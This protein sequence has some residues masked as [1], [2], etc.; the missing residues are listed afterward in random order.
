VSL[1]VAGIC[2]AVEDF[3][4]HLPDEKDDDP[5]NDLA[6]AFD[7]MDLDSADS[8]A[9]CNAI[10][11][12][13]RS[14]LQEFEGKLTSMLLSET[15]ERNRRYI[16][17]ALGNLGARSSIPL[18]LNVVRHGAGLIIGDAIE[19]LAKLQATEAETEI[20]LPMQSPTD[21]I[22]NKAKW[23]IKQFEARRREAGD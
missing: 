17:R 12:I 21:W 1:R 22:G 20:R 5:D 4:M 6:I 8:T 2:P 10:M 18:L 7:P 15:E 13:S 19:A 14:R 3:V 11:L 9:R 23:A 16:V